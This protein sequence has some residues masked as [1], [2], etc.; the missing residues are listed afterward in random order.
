MCFQAIHSVGWHHEGK[1]FMCSH[2]DGSLTMWNLRNTTKPFQVT[3]PH[4][5]NQTS[6][7]NHFQK[8]KTLITPGFD[9]SAG[10]IQPPVNEEETKELWCRMIDFGV[11]LQ[12]ELLPGCCVGNGFI[13]QSVCGGVWP[14]S[15]WPALAVCSRHLP[16]REGVITQQQVWAGNVSVR[17]WRPFTD[18]V[19]HLSHVG[20]L[21]RLGEMWEGPL[22]AP[23]RLKFNKMTR[24]DRSRRLSSTKQVS[25][26]QIGPL[27][28]KLHAT[29]C[30]VFWREL[31]L[32]IIFVVD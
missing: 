11:T 22:K 7:Q 28:L 5:E 19:A 3:F 32:T 16:S 26:F 14:P 4:G 24:D 9:H 6:P 23:N 25:S 18:Y 2:S 21:D 15:C 30:I 12:F 8:Q 13:R 1:Q 27:N 17:C 10:K 31:R 29:Q 20:L